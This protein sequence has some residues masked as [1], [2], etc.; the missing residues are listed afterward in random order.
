FSA[1]PPNSVDYAVMEKTDKAAIVAP[2]DVGWTDIGSWS[3][4]ASQSD[5]PNVIEVDGA[6]NNIIRT[7]GAVIAAAGVNNLIIIATGDSILVA[8]RDNAQEVRA[9]VDELK[10]RGRTDLL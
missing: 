6:K 7:D 2:V 10:E 8:R 9:V 3:E 4:V 5:A 1:C